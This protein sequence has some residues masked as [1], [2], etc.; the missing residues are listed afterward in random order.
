MSTAIRRPDPLARPAAAFGCLVALAI[1]VAAF[2]PKAELPDPREEALVTASRELGFYDEAGGAVTV[3][4]RATG[5]E[6]ASLG[7]G[8]G[9]FVR[10]TMRSLARERT[11][12]RI[13]RDPPF[14]LERLS[15]GTLLLGDPQTGTSIRLTAFGAANAAS[16]AAFLDEGR[17]SE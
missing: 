6:I 8:E 16:F 3:I 1:L 11:E 15:D 5:A 10:S 17:S 7:V 4:D 12:R 2:G 14:L 9:G 13:P